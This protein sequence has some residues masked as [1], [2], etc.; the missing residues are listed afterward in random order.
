MQGW[1]LGKRL[2]NEINEGYSELPSTRLQVSKDDK[3]L[4]NAMVEAAVRP[5]Q[6]Q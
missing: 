5:L 1:T 3:V 2:G 6:E 4:S